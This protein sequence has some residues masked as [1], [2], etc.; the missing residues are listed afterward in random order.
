MKIIQYLG[1]ARAMEDDMVR[2]LHA[3]AAV[4]AKGEYRRLLDRHLRETEQHRDRLDQR[5]DELGEGRRLLDA[6]VDA[7]QSVAGQLLSLY[8]LPAHAARGQRGED[9]ILS[10]A[11]QGCAAEALEIAT[12]HALEALARELGDTKTADLAQRIRADEQRMLDDLQ[13]LI[14]ALTSDAVHAEPQTP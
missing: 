8:R 4:A 14:P 2:T 13:Q 1:E 3:H 7:L 9:R 10:N 12:Y 11:R 5:L 6:G